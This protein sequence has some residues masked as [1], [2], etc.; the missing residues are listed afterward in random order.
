M[1]EILRKGTTRP[2][3][4]E[5]LE[6]YARLSDLQSR[7]P[8]PVLQHANDPHQYLMYS[9]FDGTGQDA[10]DPE[11]RPTNVGHLRAQLLKATMDPAQRTDFS[12]VRGIGTQKN[13]VARYADALIPFTWDD[14]IEEAYRAI[15]NQTAEWKAHDPDARISIVHAG[16]SRGAVLV[17]GLTRLIDRYGIADP[18][19]LS[20]GRDA[21]GNITV[22]GAKPPLAE[23][24]EV[25]QAVGLFDPVATNMPRNYDAR[26]SPSVISGLSMLAANERREAYPH[27]AIVDLEMTADGRFVGARVPGGH[28]N[29]GGGNGDEGLEALAFNA[30]ADYF[31]GL[32]DRQLFSHRALPDDPARYTVY[33]VRGITA[34][35]GLD[36]D[37]E[38]NLR[39]ELANCKIVDPCR[40]AEPVDR[41]LAEQFEY[42]L[43]RP[44]APAPAWSAMALEANR[45]SGFVAAPS[46]PGHPDHAR[47]ER[48][49]DGVRRF[50]EDAG[51]APDE[52]SERLS[53]SLLAASKEQA[54]GRVDHVVLGSDGRQVFA[55]EGGLHDPWRRWA[56][57]EVVQAMRTP[58]EQSDAKLEAANQRRAQELLEP[59][60]GMQRHAT[61]EGERQALVPSL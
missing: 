58:V 52:G 29:V 42:R 31:N 5:E 4:G 2:I 61:R 59:A 40:D 17:P 15:A 36:D 57:V 54:L 60:P 35:A 1:G 26:L 10:D 28:S 12:Y 14:K 41:A 23:P 7:Q 38:R 34:V 55:V 39:T 9:L 13:P 50:D 48:I 51:R 11:Q 19:G 33:Q 56:A 53:R 24:G 30:M 46:D 18:D 16:Y 3:T 22:I 44:S 47:L 43:L 20:F 32:S 21:H 37:G 49:R 8:V 45:D 25:A 6:L 27:Q